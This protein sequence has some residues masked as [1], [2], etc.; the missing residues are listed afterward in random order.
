MGDFKALFMLTFEKLKK[1]MKFLRKRSQFYEMLT[2][3]LKY[4]LYIA[5]V[6]K[7]SLFNLFS[8]NG[9]DVELYFHR[10][11]SYVKLRKPDKVCCVRHHLSI[12]LTLFLRQ[13]VMDINKAIVLKETSTNDDDGIGFGDLYRLRCE[14]LIIQLRS[15]FDVPFFSGPTFIIMMET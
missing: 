9:D 8:T 4:E 3:I 14:I 2:E 6:A 15:N 13:A 10:A 1:D 11:K 5:T 12:A 7:I